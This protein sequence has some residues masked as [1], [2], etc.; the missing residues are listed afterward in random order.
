MKKVWLVSVYNKFDHMNEHYLVGGSS[1]KAI[2]AL[3]KKSN[4]EL[5]VRTI[6]YINELTGAVQLKAP[7]VFLTDEQHLQY[8]K[9]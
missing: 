5:D 2:K 1:K 8:I 9:Q 6:H 4:L 3:M 7:V